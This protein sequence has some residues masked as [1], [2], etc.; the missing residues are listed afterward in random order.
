MVKWDYTLETN[1]TLSSVATV[2][3]YT[4]VFYWD[5]ILGY[6]NSFLRGFA[7]NIFQNNITDICY[8]SILYWIYYWVTAV[9][10]L[11]I[12]RVFHLFCCYSICIES[13]SKSTTLF[14]HDQEWP[15]K[16]QELSYFYTLG[17]QAHIG[18]LQSS[19]HY[20]NWYIVGCVSDLPL[21]DALKYVPWSTMFLFPLSLDLYPANT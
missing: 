8:M 5:K 12:T 9:Y 7:G 6:S 11:I 15:N 13:E 19:P 16:Q 10:K 20:I 18:M 14:L 1:A 21:L 2:H 17:A 3:C 4:Q